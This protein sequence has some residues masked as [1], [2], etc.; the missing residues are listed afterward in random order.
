MTT[1]RNNESGKI[2][3][4]KMEVLSIKKRTKV[5]LDNL[6]D[7]FRTMIREDCNKIWIKQSVFTLSNPVEGVWFVIATNADGDLQAT[8]K[9]DKFDL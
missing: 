9:F 2:G 7:A 3:D 8:A 4:R 1:K 5:T 6:F